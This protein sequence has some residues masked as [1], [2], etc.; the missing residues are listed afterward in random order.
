MNVPTILLIDDS[1]ADAQTIVAALAR[2]VPRNEVRVYADGAAALDF[3]DRPDAQPDRSSLALPRFVLLELDLPRISG[4]DVLRAIR[5][6]PATRLLPVTVLSA[7]ARQ[8]DIRI[9]AG[10]GAN[11][12]VRKSA[13]TRQMADNIVELARYWLELNIPPPIRARQ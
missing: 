11:S 12:F 9:A 3:F 7:T 5:A 13:D 10:L 4:L 1:A 8:N 6:K 2:V